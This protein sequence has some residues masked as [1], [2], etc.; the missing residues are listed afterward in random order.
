MNKIIFFFLLFAYPFFVQAQ[1]EGDLDASF[2]SNGQ[3][4]HSFFSDK[5][6][7]F[8]S[9]LRTVVGANNKTY[10]YGTFSTGNASG[11]LGLSMICIA[12]DG[13][14]D[15]SFGLNG[16][17]YFQQNSNLNASSN[18]VSVQV[19][20]L[21]RIIFGLSDHGI[22]RFLN[23]GYPDSSF[24]VNGYV[25]LSISGF[26]T[27]TLSSLLVQADGKIVSICN[28]N[29]PGTKAVLARFNQNG[30]LDSSFNNTGI[31]LGLFNTGTYNNEAKKHFLLNDGKIVVVGNANNQYNA[32]FALTR[33]L[34]D[35]T[36]DTS[37]GNNG[38]TQINYD[39]RDDFILNV[40]P[41]KQNGILIYGR[42]SLLA[43]PTTNIVAKF[44]ANGRVDST[45]GIAGRF[46]LDFYSNL[47][48]CWKNDDVL[49]GSLN[50]G[51]YKLRNY[52][53]T[54][55][56]DSTFGLSGER[57]LAKANFPLLRLTGIGLLENDQLVFGGFN[58]QLYN[59]SFGFIKLNPNVSID[60]SIGVNGLVNIQMGTLYYNSVATGKLTKIAVR[61]DK[62]I[63]AVGSALEFY[64]PKI[65]VLFFNK[66]GAVENSIGNNGQLLL[67]DGMAKAVLPLADN[68]ILIGGYVTIGESKKAILFKLKA[69]GYYDSTFGVNGRVIVNK[70]LVNNLNE[71]ND[72]D[73]QSDGKI[74][75]S[76]S[77]IARF[78]ANGQ[79]DSS[80]G[81]L[82]F[83]LGVYSLNSV[84][85]K[86]NSFVVAGD[87]VLS[88]YTADGKSI[89]WNYAEKKSHYCGQGV[90]TRI[91]N[92]AF[93]EPF[94]NKDE[95]IFVRGG[96]YFD[97]EYNTSIGCSGLM[98]G[99][100]VQYLFNPNG[101]PVSSFGSNGK[102]ISYS[103]RLQ[104]AALSLGYKVLCISDTEVL[105]GYNMYKYLKNGGLDGP[106]GNAG[107]RH[108]PQSLIKTGTLPRLYQ[109]G[110]QNDTS[111][112]V[113]FLQ[114]DT[115]FFAKHFMRKDEAVD[116][117]ITSKSAGFV[118]DT[119]R[120]S[121]SAT[122]GI[123]SYRWSIPGAI[124]LNGTD[125]S[126]ANPE[127]T[128]TTLG[129]KS[130]TLE[131]IGANGGVIDTKTRVNIIT[132]CRLDFLAS[133]NSGSVAEPIQLFPSVFPL[134]TSYRWEIEG[135]PQF[136]SGYNLQ[137]E[138][139]YFRYLQTGSFTIK[140]TIK[141]GDK[142]SFTLSKTNFIRI[143]SLN[144]TQDK[145]YG[146]L[147]DSP[148]FEFFANSIPVAERYLWS[149]KPASGQLGNPVSIIGNQLANASIIANDTG[150][151]DVQLIAYY[152]GS[153]SLVKVKNK[154]IY[155]GI[156]P[157]TN[158]PVAQFS[159]SKQ[160]GEIDE[161][162][163]F[164]DSSAYF[165][166]AWEWTITP[167]NIWLVESDYN[168]Q[169]PIVSFYE[170][171]TYTVKLKVSNSFGID[172]IIKL[173]YIQIGSV[174]LLEPNK[175]REFIIYPNP[176]KEQ[177]FVKFMGN[178]S[179]QIEIYNSW[180]VLV[181]EDLYTNN[182][183]D[184]MQINIAH[185]AEGFYYIKLRSH[186]NEIG[187]TFVLNR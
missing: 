101:V 60:T 115:L 106:F 127:I 24:G 160:S 14:I 84:V 179:P 162:F 77:G 10:L 122:Q 63:I 56:I 58:D 80:F 30:T 38:I 156:K 155:V 158:K 12:V 143:Y 107:K 89:L 167:N 42:V 148:R 132:V 6:R 161:L 2:G 182:S 103:L 105:Y 172:S 110:F 3:I 149:A 8:S 16:R 92:Y 130:V 147:N 7:A 45:F 165:P 159:V 39:Y 139:P 153:D 33:Y 4:A 121:A 82:G 1:V 21:N 150:W 183:L 86:D 104:T 50:A 81:Q 31:I 175:N 120:L 125:S 114:N 97:P 53:K 126:S 68:S 152:V 129:Y 94:I 95:N 141:Y 98:N 144:F 73:L 178:E 164:Q 174:G 163:Y 66:N 49:L 186:Q 52:L 181:Y 145:S 43:G 116:F 157:I 15:S 176:A 128:F 69:N 28:L 154:A 151:Y 47:L 177:L 83:N 9:V 113:A 134:P 138:K 13:R 111:L 78:L 173:N 76:G 18:V 32:D 41:T 37:Y 124:Y 59:T 54:G 187:R 166:T 109:V 36:L 71:F 184:A 20:S 27:T 62:T 11:A 72:L 55:V 102:K 135:N 142:D 34:P 26:A 46:T 29:N 70:Q 79:L 123:A 118:S 57:T 93:Y 75:A 100:D 168:S 74:I 5:K 23:T 140:L 51:E 19:D 185:L 171:G 67:E 180:G 22:L 108:F 85:L 48:I 40:A 35:G 61:P 87:T 99:G 96:T 136:Y 137:V 117:S 44:L 25:K 65:R 146:T 88:K 17:V 112:I 170:N 91:F 119:F 90:G 64:T 169:N 133:L 131:G